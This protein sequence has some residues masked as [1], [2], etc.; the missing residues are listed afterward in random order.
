VSADLL[1]Q[2]PRLRRG[3]RFQYEPAQ[4]AYVLLY[5]EGMVK[6]NGSAAEILG[7]VDG[8]RDVAAIVAALQA[9]FPGFPALQADVLEFIEVARDKHWIELR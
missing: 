8:E 9:R 6:L 2:V 4:D 7:Q 5:P 3:Y 1:R